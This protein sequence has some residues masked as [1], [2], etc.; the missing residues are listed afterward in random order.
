[1]RARRTHSTNGTVAYPGDPSRDLPVRYANVDDR[2]A[3]FSVWAL[4]PEE[5][6]AIA[7]GKANIELGVWGNVHPPVS[8]GITRER[9]LPIRPD[10]R[11]PDGKTL[12][13]ELDRDRVV[14]VVEL[15]TRLDGG[16]CL[17]AGARDRLE[18]LRE[19]LLEWLPTLTEEASDA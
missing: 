18:E 4:K 15:L 12:F 19:A 1:M 3:M 14:D 10:E 16:A 11:I 8:L 5:R 17:R 2:P 13:I 7:T 9:V 6:A